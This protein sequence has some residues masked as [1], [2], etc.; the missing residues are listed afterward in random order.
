[1]KYNFDEQVNRRGTG[2][3]KWDVD[4]TETEFSAKKSGSYYYYTFTMHIDYLTT[5]S[6]RKK[7]DAKVDEVISSFK[8]TNKTST[9]EKIKKVTF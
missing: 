8:F 7:L 2:S 6:E 4:E 9:H 5:L 3:M 1:M